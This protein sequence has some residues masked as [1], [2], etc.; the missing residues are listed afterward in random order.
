[1]TRGGIW[2]R[3]KEDTMVNFKSPSKRARRSSIFPRKLLRYN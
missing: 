3:H 2:I 1:M